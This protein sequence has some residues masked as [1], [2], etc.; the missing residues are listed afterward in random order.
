MKKL[1]TFLLLTLATSIHP[2]YLSTTTPSEHSLTELQNINQQIDS[3][4]KQLSE[5]RRKAVNKEIHAQT[6]MIDNWHEFAED[7]N[8][9]EESEQHILA[10]KKKIHELNDRKETIL[11][12]TS[13]Q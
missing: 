5:M 6:Y 2:F 12:E 4:E 7:I 11:K 1:P 10:I 9:A 8:A 3:L 13:S